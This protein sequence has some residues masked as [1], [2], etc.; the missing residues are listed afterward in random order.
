MRT[1]HRSSRRL[2]RTSALAVVA[3]FAL[4]GC[5]PGQSQP[6]GYGD[7]NDKGEGYYGNF[8]FGCTGVEPTEGKYVDV[9]LENPDFCRCVFEGL[10][11]KV[12]FDDVKQ[13]EEA[14]AEAESGADIE[15]PANIEAVRK[16]CAD[17]ASTP[18]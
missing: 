12:P 6:T 3:L 1:Q 4:A 15:I 18:S 10:K 13:F 14:Q 11:E 9:T 5:A 16:S 2:A 7:V 8:M 17:E